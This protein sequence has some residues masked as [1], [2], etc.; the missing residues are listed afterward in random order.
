MAKGNA[1]RWTQLQGIG[2]QDSQQPG[3]EYLTRE[4]YLGSTSMSTARPSQAACPNIHSIPSVLTWLSCAAS[5]C[6]R[7]CCH[8]SPQ[9]SRREVEYAILVPSDSLCI[10][11]YVW[12]FSFPLILSQIPPN[13]SDVIAYI[14]S[15]PCSTLKTLCSSLQLMA[16]GNPTKHFFFLAKPESYKYLAWHL[17]DL[18][19]CKICF[20]AE[21]FKF[22]P[23]YLAHP[24]P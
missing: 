2:C 15:N 22:S 12:E 21:S 10:W 23:L 16:L 20:Q 5:N 9:M 18:F 13:C 4:G 6:L 17:V 11:E 14:L 8:P 7:R 19:L 3:N 24:S 1:W